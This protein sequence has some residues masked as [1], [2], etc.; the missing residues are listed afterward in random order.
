MD[1][2]NDV[3]EQKIAD[4]LL[5]KTS[6]GESISEE[7]NALPFDERLS[8]ANKMQATAKSSADIPDLTLKTAKD[9]LGNDHLI[10]MKVEGEWGGFFNSKPFTDADVY[11][12]NLT[13]NAVPGFGINDKFQLDME[14]AKDVEISIRTETIKN[15]RK[16]QTLPEFELYEELVKM[17]RHQ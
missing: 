9:S 6:R 4:T 1:L 7:L 8:I 17:Q 14:L 13:D 10:D 12:L 11:D 2:F 3:T 5:A 16:G 15:E